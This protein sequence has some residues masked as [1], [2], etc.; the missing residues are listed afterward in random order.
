MRG[1]KCVISTEWRR[2]VDSGAFLGCAPCRV[3]LESEVVMDCGSALLKLIK[4]NLTHLGGNV[5]RLFLHVF[6]NLARDV[7][8]EAIA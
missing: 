1:I 5:S 6:A 3:L 4:F 8:G 7:D 2:G